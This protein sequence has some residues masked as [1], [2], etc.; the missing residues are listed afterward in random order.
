MSVLE[1][2]SIIDAWLG[3][4]YDREYCI[5]FLKKCKMKWILGTSNRRTHNIFKTFSEG[6]FRNVL[7]ASTKLPLQDTDLGCRTEESLGRQI[8]KSPGSQ[9]WISPWWSNR[10]FRRRCR[11]TGWG[12]SWK[13]LGS[14]IFQLGLFFLLIFQLISTY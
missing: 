11:V 14:N 8:G 6:P 3:S 9:M 4:K 1:K 12:Y 5:E 2:S 13:V 10:V 7:R